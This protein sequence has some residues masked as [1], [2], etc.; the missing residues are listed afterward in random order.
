MIVMRLAKRTRTQAAIEYLTTYGWAILAIAVALAVLFQLGDF[1]GTNFVTTT[2]IGESGYLCTHAVMNVSG[3]AEVVLGQV[4]AATLNV[5]GVGCSGN[6]SA[7]SNFTAIFLPLG[8]STVSMQSDQEYTAVFRCPISPE[9]VFGTTFDG[10]VWVRYS[11]P[12]GVGETQMACFTQSHQHTSS[13]WC[14]P[15]C[16]LQTTAAAL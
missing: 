12:E 6:S 7:P 10:Y 3:Y 11:S 5:T 13:F 1:G 2:C 14:S 8:N 16:S 4:G 15:S 9:D